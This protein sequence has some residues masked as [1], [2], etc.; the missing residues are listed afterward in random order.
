MLTAAKTYICKVLENPV[1]AESELLMK[2]IDILVVAVILGIVSLVVWYI[3]KSKK[4]GI[5][6]IGC[7]DG[8][9]CAGNCAGCAGNCGGCDAKNSSK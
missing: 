9:K 5:K 3:Y 7:P 1:N 8:A 6:C 4:K 2:L